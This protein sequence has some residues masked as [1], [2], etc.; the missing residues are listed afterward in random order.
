MTDTYIT[1]VA[2]VTGASQ[3]IGRAVAL[4]LARD[5]IDV[6]VNDIDAKKTQLEGVVSEIQ[7]LGRKSVALIADVSVEEQVKKMVVDTVQSFGC[8]DIV[9]FRCYLGPQCHIDTCSPDGG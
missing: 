5:G 1:R 8:L 9:S 2:I 3:G 7:S 4:R 6:A